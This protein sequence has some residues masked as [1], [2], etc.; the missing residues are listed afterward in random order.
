MERD[1]IPYVDDREASGVIGVARQTLA[2]WRYL[3]KGPCYVKN[4]RL[5]RYAVTDLLAF[6]DARKVGTEDQPIL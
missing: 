2:N 1:R 5:V 6:M 4:G 3:R